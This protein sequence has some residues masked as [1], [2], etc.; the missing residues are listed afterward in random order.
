MEKAVRFLNFMINRKRPSFSK[1]KLICDLFNKWIQI[2]NTKQSSTIYC[3]ETF[4]MNKAAFSTMP[5]ILL[6]ESA[7]GTCLKS[8]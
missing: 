2:I 7:M 5:A 3:R 8:E 1:H 4:S 6:F